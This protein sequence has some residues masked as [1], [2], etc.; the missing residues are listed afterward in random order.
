MLLGLR[1]VTYLLAASCGFF[2]TPAPSLSDRPAARFDPPAYEAVE[3]V[4]AENTACSDDSIALLAAE[5]VSPP[6]TPNAL[7]SD[8]SSY[9]L[10]QLSNSS[11]VCN[12]EK[13]SLLSGFGLPIKPYYYNSLSMVPLRFIAE[14][15]DYS[16]SWDEASQ[17]IAVVGNDTDIVLTVGKSSAEING[18]ALDLT[19]PVALNKGTVY[20]PARAFCQLLGCYIHYYDKSNGDYLLISDYPISS[21]DLAGDSTANDNY[22]NVAPDNSLESYKDLGF[23]Y[24]GPSPS[25]YSSC[26]L[27][28]RCDCT[29]CLLNGD[30]TLITTDS[31]PTAPILAADGNVYVPLDFCAQSFGAQTATTAEGNLS[32]TTEDST[33]VFPL[34]SGYYVQ[35]GQTIADGCYITREVDGVV[36]TTVQTIAAALDVY[37]TFS[38]SEIAVLS[39]YSPDNYNNI[40]DFNDAAAAKLLLLPTVKYAALTFDDGPSGSLTER[41][42]D[43]LAQRDVRATFF[44]CNYRIVQYPELME[45]YAAGGHELGNHSASHTNLTRLS[46][47]GI[48]TEIDTTNEA[49][50]QYT[51]ISPRLFRP[52]GGSYNDRVLSALAD[53]SMSCI[54][55][56]VDPKDWRDH[57]SGVVV[58]RVLSAVMDGS[59]IL[60]HDMYGTSVDAG[61]AII[62]RLEAEGYKFVTV[63]DLAFVKG[64]DLQAG[65]VYR[66]FP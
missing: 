41:L 66:S 35:D 31:G 10:L 47:R 50:V 62:D 9:I 53:R 26:T 38:D 49:I 55:W 11:A 43:G 60:L 20:V 22:S 42:L 30:D 54:L 29:H 32:I 51:D 33:S 2:V 18:E 6:D 13:I 21:G 8:S 3:P 56:S 34:V 59:I 37:Y 14:T 15:F 23:D 61:L 28:F 52:P 17:S 1:L 40:E 58:N 44:L 36:Y 25:T 48:D 7:S 16:V 64:Y 46:G 24:L 12:G 27:F 65:Q 5:N 57:D 45:R 19:A 63:S 39:T 4:Q